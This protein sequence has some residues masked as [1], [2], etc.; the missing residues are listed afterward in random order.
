MKEEKVNTIDEYINLQPETIRPKLKKIREVIAKAVPEAKESI[1]YRMPLFKFNGM[2]AYFA[3]FTNHYSIFVSPPVMNEFRTR[4][5][6]YDLSKSGI[7]IKNSMPVP[8]KL[9][10]EIVKYAA[11]RNARQAELKKT[12]KKKK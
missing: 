5:E 11:E 4:L 10:K 7:R 3:A 6:G 2:I 8:E 12:S 1:S 9:L